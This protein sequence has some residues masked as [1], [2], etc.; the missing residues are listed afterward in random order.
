MIRNS[1][2]KML[3]LLVLVALC[4]AV[5][6]G[7]AVTT[8]VNGQILGKDGK[9]VEG[10]EIKF[11]R[12]DIK[13]N[14]SIKTNKDGKFVYATLPQ[15]VFTISVTVAGNVIAKQEGIRTNP[16]KP[17]PLD[18]D[19]RKIPDGQAAAVQADAAPPKPTA[20]E[21]AEFEKKKQEYEASAAK[22]KNLQSAFTAAM[23][24]AQAKN[25]NVA[26]ENFIKAGEVD[27]TQEAV[28]ANLANVYSMRAES[29]RGPAAVAD[30]GRASEAYAKAVALKP[31]DPN[32]HNNYATVAAR[33]QKI[34]VAQAEL[35]KAIELDAPGAGKYYR[36]L[37]R[38]YFDTNQ[39][40]PA[41][42]AFKKSIAL[43][44]RD[45]D[46]HFQLGLVLIQQATLE[47]EKM[48]AP[49]GTAEEFQKYLELA[50]TG[51]NAAE[52][53]AMLDALGAP[54]K[55]TVTNTKGKNK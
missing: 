4:G 43:D 50:P 42:A 7:Q 54:V 23:E 53:K 41:E 2:P 39:T 46:A 49:A 16:S 15:G 19:M 38:V 10:A 18:I 6:Y 30:Y 12:T 48:K 25:W 9:P 45:P 26:I 20:E 14:Y 44:P 55:S 22:E 1:L 28:W 13:A 37:A 8:T 3:I 32:L 24:A 21:L 27:P 52:A 34:D 17:L 51:A 5:F 31:L 40:G 33:A 35:N 29:Q 11:E 36:N 47:G